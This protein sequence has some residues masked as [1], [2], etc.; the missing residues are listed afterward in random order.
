MDFTDDGQYNISYSEMIWTAIASMGW[1]VI[2][3]AISFWYVSPYIWKRYINWKLRKD[4]QDYAAKYH[5]NTDLLQETLSA[6]EAS[7]QKM[8]QEYYRKCMFARQEEKERKEKQKERFRS[9][10][11]NDAGHES[12]NKKNEWFSIGKNKSTSIR[13]E[14]NP[15]MGDD[16]R[17]YR[18]PRRRCCGNGNC[19]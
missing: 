9:I 13:G 3:I 4:E 16:S 15:L 12:G 7:R 8:Q 18:P 11:A 17:G 14:Y 1:Y 2:A 10:D 5:K 6:L 19:G